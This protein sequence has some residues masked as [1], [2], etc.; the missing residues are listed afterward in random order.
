MPLWGS[1]LA[2]YGVGVGVLASQMNQPE[3]VI[4]LVPKRSARSMRLVLLAVF[5]E[6]ERCHLGTRPCGQ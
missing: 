1:R 4:H 2:S 6:L 5:R 3:A